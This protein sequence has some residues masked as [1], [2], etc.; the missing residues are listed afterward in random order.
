MSDKVSTVFTPNVGRDRVRKD[1]VGSAPTFC[2]WPF[3]CFGLSG[4]G[5]YSFDGEGF[6]IRA[7]LRDI[8]TYD[9][10]LYGAN[11]GTAMLGLLNGENIADL[12]KR[13][14]LKRGY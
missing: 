11:V 6:G 3:G 4:E 5:T 13:N 8:S 9:R 7:N 12:W 14:P 10:F 1:M 2:L